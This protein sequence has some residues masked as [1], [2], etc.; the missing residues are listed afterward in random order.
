MMKEYTRNKRGKAV[1]KAM[2]RAVLPTSPPRD[3]PPCALLLY[4]PKRPLNQPA[5]LLKR[6]CSKLKSFKH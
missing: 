6:Q 3:P 5:V 1:L 4:E 2:F